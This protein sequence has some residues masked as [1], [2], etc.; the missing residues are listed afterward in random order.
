LDLLLLDP[1]G[2]DMWEGR[3]GRSDEDGRGADFEGA[4]DSCSGESIGADYEVDVVVGVDGCEESGRDG[5]GG[6]GSGGSSSHD[7]RLVP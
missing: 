3:G 6:S 4:G 1:A 2:E 7:R 5:G